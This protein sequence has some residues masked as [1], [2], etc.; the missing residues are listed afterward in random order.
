LDI[1]FDHHRYAPYANLFTEIDV[2]EGSRMFQSG[3]GASLGRHSAAWTTFWNIQSQRPIDWPAGWSPELINIIGV[4]ARTSS[5]LGEN[6]QAR[7]FEAIPPK[8]LSP[9]NLYQ[10]QLSK[11]LASQE[12]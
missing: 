6:Q 4:N 3:G 2:G 10:S 8:H 5:M 1:C 12:R 9:S 11:R 7:W